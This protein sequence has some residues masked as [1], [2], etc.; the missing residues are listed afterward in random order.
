MVKT[1]L[2][3]RLCGIVLLYTF[4]RSV[5]Y[6]RCLA[7]Q[8]FHSVKRSLR[9]HTHRDHRT[10]RSLSLHWFHSDC[11]MLSLIYIL[12]LTPDPLNIRYHNRILNLNHFRPGNHCLS[13]QYHN[14][15]QPPLLRASHH[16]EQRATRLELRLVPKLRHPIHGLQVL[17]PSSTKQNQLRFCTVVHL[18]VRGDPSGFGQATLR[19]PGSHR[20]RVLRKDFAQ[21]PHPLTY[22]EQHLRSIKERLD[23]S[24]N[25]AC[26]HDGLRDAT[27]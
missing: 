2:T 27:S 16:G 15:L 18:R 17:G 12:P 13:Q 8:S 11:P 5:S 1:L 4:L 24:A 25:V 21:G 20:S 10:L 9:P 26:A 3:R 6:T 19:V 14:S 22:D 23:R 7:F